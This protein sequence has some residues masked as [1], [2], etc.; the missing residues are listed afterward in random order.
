LSKPTAFSDDISASILCLDASTPACSAAL[1]HKGHCFSRFEI[2]SRQH[3][4]RLLPMVDEVVNDAGVNL[5][6][7]D[8]LALTTGPG[9]FTGIRIGFGVVQ[10]LAFG[11]QL[12]VIPVSTLE[13]MAQ[14][15]ATRLSLNAGEL[16]MPVL[17]ARM[18]ECYWAVFCVGSDGAVIR[19][20]PDQLSAP[21]Q[22]LPDI[23][24][25]KTILVGDGWNYAGRFQFEPAKVEPEFFPSAQAMLTIAARCY[26]QGDAKP[27]ECVEPLYLRDK[28]TWKKRQRLRQ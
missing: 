2:A 20:E 26:L 8:A 11:A 5:A 14:E 9:S 25:G 6:E 1:L 27:I 24:F 10:G 21:E 28:I 13:A 17:D 22:I 15:A 7:L 4:Q 16:V 23:D 19:L 3:T 12:P 18:D